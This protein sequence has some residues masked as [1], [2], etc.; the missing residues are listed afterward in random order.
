MHKMSAK[1]AENHNRIIL[2][3]SLVHLLSVHSGQGMCRGCGQSCNHELLSLLEE[4]EDSPSAGP[5]EP[6]ELDLLLDG[7]SEAASS[8]GLFGDT[9]ATAL[10]E[11][12]GL[13]RALPLLFGVDFALALA[14]ALP[15]GAAAALASKTSSV[16]SKCAAGGAGYPAS[17]ASN[18]LL[19]SSS[20]CLGSTC[21]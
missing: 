14:R 4:E 21:L 5:K 8:L 11:G 9:L 2:R 3:Q 15:F 16:S 7:G 1:H 19:S 13:G 6:D 20:T 18:T 10:G 12:A 17:R